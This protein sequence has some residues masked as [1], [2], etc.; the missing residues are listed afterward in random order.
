MSAE[1]AS[2]FVVA[3]D[4]VTAIT[5]LVVLRLGGASRRVRFVSGSV[6]VGWL[7]FL[8]ATIPRSALFAAE[9]SGVAVLGAILGTA[10]VATALMFATPLRRTLLALPVEL[11][12]LP[13][14]M[15]MFLGAGF[16]V[17]AATGSMPSAFGIADGLSHI[18]AAFLATL[19]AV[20]YAKGFDYRAGAWLASLF[21][22]LDIVAVVLGICFVLLP[23]IGPHHNVMYVAL[24]AGPLFVGLHLVT[25]YRLVTEPRLGRPMSEFMSYSSSGGADVQPSTLRPDSVST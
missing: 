3:L 20:A 7:G 14:G 1:V 5:F 21:G 8:L 11:T 24:F 6:L 15:R 19:T 13:Q 4:V 23:A 2:S 16:L 17:Q 22:L 12:L 9:A 25:I 18:T 10:A